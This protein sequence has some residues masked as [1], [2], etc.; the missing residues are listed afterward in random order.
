[1][2]RP[3]YYNLTFITAFL[4][5]VSGC[6]SDQLMATGKNMAKTNCQKEHSTNSSKYFDCVKNAEETHTTQPAKK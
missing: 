4:F 2:T 1:M 5:A 3:Y 6:T